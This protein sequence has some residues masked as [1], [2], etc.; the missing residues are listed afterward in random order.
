GM[1][2]INPCT[3]ITKA[4]AQPLFSTPLADG[5]TDHQGKC[6]YTLVDSSLGDGLDINVWTGSDFRFGYDNL[7]SATG[8][9]GVTTLAGVGD[10]AKWTLLAGYFPQ[11]EAIKGQVGCDVTASGANGQL[12]VATTG[13][14]MFAVIDPT[15]LD[16]FMAKFGALCNLVF[17]ANPPAQ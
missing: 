16:G 15:A 7:M 14:Q 2:D 8:S 1:P 10:Q 5:T 11:V 9:A 17:A 13:K 4:A 6:D 3:M 12:S